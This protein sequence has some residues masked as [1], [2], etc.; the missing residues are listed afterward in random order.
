M[1]GDMNGRTGTLMDYIENDAGLSVDTP[2]ST[3]LTKKSSGS[4]R[5]KV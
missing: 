1:C 3:L 2:L 4:Q 5:T